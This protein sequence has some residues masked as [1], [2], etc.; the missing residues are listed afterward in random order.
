[1]RRINFQRLILALAL[2]AGGLQLS[3]CS[4]VSEPKSVAPAVVRAAPKIALV[5][6]GGGTRGFAHVGVIKA[7]EAQGI[8]PDIIVGTSV[9]SAIGALYAAG[10]NGFQLQEMSIPMKEERVVDWSWPNR[11][12]FTGKPL[13]TYINQSIKQVPLEKL[14]RTFAV[15]ATDLATGEKVVFRTGNTGVA[16]SAS[17]AVPGVFQPV[18]ING[19][20]YVDGGLV[21]PVPAAEARALGADFVIAV[22][23]SNQPQNNKTESTVDVLMQTFDIM[24]QTINRYELVNADV[25]I[26]PVTRNIAQGNLD[27]RHLAILEGEKAVAVILPEL[28]ARLDRLRRE[29]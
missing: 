19:R 17:C 13:Q 25:V 11:G 29:R 12:L 7:L 26:R 28:K 16:V 6:G 18:V 9:G 24:S 4:T 2:T 3:A 22:N 5:L 23:I 27:D 20:S 8:V 21:R 14:R 15:V 1:M 10:Y